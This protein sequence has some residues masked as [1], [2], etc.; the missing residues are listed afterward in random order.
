V[1]VGDGGL[2][3]LKLIAV[4]GV[5]DTRQSERGDCKKNPGG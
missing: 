1:N 4:P 5:R 2:D 3:Q